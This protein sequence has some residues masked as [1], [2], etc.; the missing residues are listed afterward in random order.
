MLA[1]KKYYIERDVIPKS[2]IDMWPVPLLHAFKD[3]AS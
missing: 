3:L 2:I 1:R